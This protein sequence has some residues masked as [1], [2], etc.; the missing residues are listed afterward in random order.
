MTDV[1]EN[2]Q[3]KQEIKEMDHKRRR[4]TKVISIICAV[5][6]SSIEQSG[7]VEHIAKEHNYLAWKEGEEPLVSNSYLNLLHL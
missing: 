1:V 2:K 7:W 6:S 5:C 3:K 4:K